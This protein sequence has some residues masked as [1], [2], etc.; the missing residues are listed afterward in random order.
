[1]NQMWILLEHLKTKAISKVSSIKT[2]DLSTLYT[3]IPHEQ[4]ESRLSDIISYFICKNGLRRYKY[5][6]VNSLLG[7][8]IKSSVESWFTN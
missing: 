3:T 6:F 1:M 8:L 5:V 4:L 2:F 7:N